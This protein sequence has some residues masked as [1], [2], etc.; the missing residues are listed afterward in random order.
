MVLPKREKM[1]SN[2]AC[3]SSRSS[4]R[5]LTHGG[6][7]RLLHSTGEQLTERTRPRVHHEL[8]CSFKRAS[9]SSD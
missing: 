5:K 4:M 7:A 1:R 8:C 9:H 2:N 6:V 3:L